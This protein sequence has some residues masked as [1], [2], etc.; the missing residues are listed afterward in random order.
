MIQ[1]IVL[2]QYG[3]LFI[4]EV[5]ISF[6]KKTL[7]DLVLQNPWAYLHFK[8]HFDS[9][10]SAAL[11]SHFHIFSVK[12]SKYTVKSSIDLSQHIPKLNYLKRISLQVPQFHNNYLNHISD[13]IDSQVETRINFLLGNFDLRNTYLY[14]VH[15]SYHSV[16]YSDSY[17]CGK[18]YVQI[19]QMNVPAA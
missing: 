13:T 19:S 2:V 18:I 10:S 4:F 12:S 5:P 7:V 6:S 3:Q 16:H 8:A 15:F 14:T 17:N 11:I 9:S 1:T